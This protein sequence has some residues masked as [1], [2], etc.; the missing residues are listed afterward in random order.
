MVEKPDS[1]DEPAAGNFLKKSDSKKRKPEGDPETGERPKRSKTI[2]GK[3]SNRRN[4]KDAVE[5]PVVVSKLIE[6]WH[7]D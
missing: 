7:T 3:E 4:G 5:E 6:G 1:E 2:R